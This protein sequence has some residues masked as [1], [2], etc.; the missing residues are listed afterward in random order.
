MSSASIWI[1]FGIALI[2]VIVLTFFLSKKEKECR[3]RIE[4]SSDNEERVALRKRIKLLRTYSVVASISLFVIS[5][6]LFLAK[7]RSASAF[8]ISCVIA[9]A[10]IYN[11]FQ[12]WTMQLKE[13]KMLGNISS[14]SKESFLKENKRF[15]LYLRGFN[16]DNYAHEKHIYELFSKEEFSEY[17]FFMK[18]QE[19]IPVCAV[20]MTK[21]F[22]SPFGAQRIYLDDNTWRKDVKDLMEKA[23]RIYI[24]VNDRESCIWE[25]KQSSEFLGKTGDLVFPELNDLPDKKTNYFLRFVKNEYVVDTFHN[26]EQDYARIQGVFDCPYYAK[27]MEYARNKYGRKKVWFIGTIVAVFVYALMMGIGA[28]LPDSYSGNLAFLQI[29]II[30]DLTLYFFFLA[31]LLG[32]RARENYEKRIRQLT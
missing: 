7:E 24:L 29:I 3:N 16:N 13:N 23:S 22:D 26:D 5:I 25:I 21:E 32:D 15:V 10:A 17:F 4:S 19:H 31:V 27:Q 1:V 20:G 30:A 14:L 18:T 11:S 28:L 2:V 8:G 6:I 9:V 12:Y